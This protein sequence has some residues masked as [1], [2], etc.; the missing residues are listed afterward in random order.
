MSSLLQKIKQYE[1]SGGP[2]DHF[3]TLG[4]EII[5]DMK[6]LGGELKA[7]NTNI[8][9][10][11]EKLNELFEAYLKLPQSLYQNHSQ[12]I[13]DFI[14]SFCPLN[15]YKAFVENIIKLP[16]HIDMEIQVKNNEDLALYMITDFV[17]KVSIKELF[18]YI[19]VFDVK[20]TKNAQIKLLLAELLIYVLN[21]IDKKEKFIDDILPRLLR[22]LHPSLKKFVKYKGRAENNEYEKTPIHIV[23]YIL[24]YEKWIKDIIT[25]IMHSIV[26][27]IHTYQNDR[28]LL[29]VKDLFEFKDD[30]LIRKEVDQK[31]TLPHYCILFIL[32]L[33][34]GLND[35]KGN[36][37]F[38]AES[39]EELINNTFKALLEIHP[40]LTD[41]ISNFIDQINVLKYDNTLSE[42]NTR[43]S[44]NLP[45]SHYDKYTIYNPA[46]ISFLC[47]KLMETP[48]ESS[49][50]EIKYKLKM[51]FICLHQLFK[52]ARQKDNIK[53]ALM[54]H[55][56]TLLKSFS[57]LHAGTIQNHNLFDMPLHDITTTILDYAGGPLDE[58]KRGLGVSIYMSIKSLFTEKALASF[59]LKGINISNNPTLTG[60]YISEFKGGIIGVLKKCNNENIKD[61][62][63]SFLD[64]NT[65]NLF[66]NI[67]INT[68]SP[69]YKDDLDLVSS[70]LNILIMVYMRLSNIMKEMKNYKETKF[71]DINN[72]FS[73]NNFEGLLRLGEQARDL[74]KKILADLDLVSTRIEEITKE[75]TEGTTQDI[76]GNQKVYVKYN[77]LSMIK[78][79]I[80]RIEDLYNELK[81]L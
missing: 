61:V 65:L 14:L 7:E 68:K 41:Y 17:E 51:L 28:S 19:K 31:K 36:T 27:I 29:L 62:E 1:E 63:S 42:F 57:T 70:S 11:P 76:D 72:I 44:F 37:Y 55:I 64:F 54:N 79:S 59:L 22:L 73:P 4:I 32:D 50:L 21:N 13:F 43:D 74:K 49:L 5:E 71:K 26:V 10:Q 30:K 34:E 6:K 33:L 23:Q 77:E 46:S 81:G 53:E 39:S 25:N 56:N 16:R 9:N 8:E 18:L 12:E 20:K 78:L 15:I 52:Y 47:A 2:N 35:V 40:L 3:S 58:K 38:P 75:E 60:F 45:T 67:S 69:Q 66:F 48:Q 80:E 24:H